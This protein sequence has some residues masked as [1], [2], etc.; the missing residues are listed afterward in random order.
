MREALFQPIRIRNLELK[1]RIVFPPLT[2]AYE[3]NYMPSKRSLHFYKTIAKGGAGLI[4]IGDLSVS[5]NYSM[6]PHFYDDS[7]IPSNQLL[8]DTIHAAGAKIGAQIYHGEYN[9]SELDEIF[10]QKGIRAVK[11]KMH[12]D[13]FTYCNKISI[14][15][16]HTIQKRILEAAIRANSCGYDL[17]QIHGDRITGMFSSPILNKRTDKYGGSLQ[18]RARF[19]LELTHMIRKALPDKPLEYKLVMIRTNPSLGMGGPTMEEGKIFAKWLEEAGIDSFHVSLAN[20]GFIGDTIPAM[21]TVPNGCFLDLAENI[22]SVTNLPVTAVGRITSPSLAEEILLTKKADLV[23]IGR[24]LIADPQWPNKVMANQ[25]DSIRP[26]IMCNRGC[27]D[28]IMQRKYIQCTVNPLNGLEEDPITIK[29]DY[30]QSVLIIGGG[31]SG[32]EAAISLCNQGH[33]ITLAEKESVLGGQLNLASLPP[34]KEEI[35]P[36]QEYLI[37]TIHSLPVEVITGTLVD[38]KFIDLNAFQKIIIATGAKPIHIPI[39]GCDPSIVCTAWDILSGKDLPGKNVLV[40][41]AGSVGIETAIY[42]ASKGSTVTVVE[43]TD[44]LLPTEVVTLKPK[45]KKELSHY[46]IEVLLEHALIKLDGNEAYINDLKKGSSFTL[47]VN[48]VVLAVG[49]RPDKL[50]QSLLERKNISF[51]SIGDCSKERVGLI[52]DAI[53]DG[54]F[55]D[56]Q[57]SAFLT[58]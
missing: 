11:E 37:K 41:G 23:A 2:T 54:Y 25:E 1:N 56:I 30:S 17:I 6:N 35:K 3:V 32:L 43:I 45:L 21:G 10:Q 22:S 42:V 40:V 36:F 55:L 12:E 49:A 38:E 33:H 39:P 52:G 19:S 20:H 18:N 24:Q 15:E 29:S 50:V 57:A 34:G 48:Q 4:I 9:P 46:Q 28:N 26:C 47:S 44:T 51:Y 16:I 5:K 31:P 14:N 58:T 8:V 7:F 27:T 53:R 13:L